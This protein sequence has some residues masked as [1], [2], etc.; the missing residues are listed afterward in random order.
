MG[1]VS[2]ELIETKVPPLFK[3][4]QQV[5]RLLCA[6]N[7]NNFCPLLPHFFLFFAAKG[8]RLCRSLATWPAAI[9]AVSIFVS[10][11]VNSSMP[12]PT[13]DGW[14]LELTRIETNWDAWA[15]GLRQEQARKWEGTWWEGLK[16]GGVS[17][18]YTISHSCFYFVFFIIFLKD[19][20][21]TWMKLKSSC[22]S[23]H[24]CILATIEE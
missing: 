1:G 19:C 7:P 23:I 11:C 16:G 13:W 10:I 12:P 8:Q 6:L 22:Y 9:S 21:S 14:D 4:V 17:S 20:S 2:G 24:Q 3:I 15:W 18:R 5:Q